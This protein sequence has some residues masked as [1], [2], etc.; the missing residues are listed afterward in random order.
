M[1]G[2][3]FFLSIA[4]YKLGNLI[5]IDSLGISGIEKRIPI[6]NSKDTMIYI[7]NNTDKIR[8]DMINTNFKIMVGGKLV[9]DSLNLMIK[10]PG[11]G[12]MRK[13]KESE[14]YRLREVQQCG[15]HRLGIALNKRIPI[16]AYTS[17]FEMGAGRNSYCLLADELPEMWHE[18]F[19]VKHYYLFFLEI[20]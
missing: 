1:K 20:K 12:I 2:K 17:P 9:E 15:N 6:I 19:K 8:Y 13:L 4:E 7:L 16:L 10:Y 3:H 18:K 5:K 14:R 11:M